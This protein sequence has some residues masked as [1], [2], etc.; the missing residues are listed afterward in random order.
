MKTP[1]PRP[2]DHVRL[3]LSTSSFVS[4]FAGCREEESVR[5]DS[6]FTGSALPIHP[7]CNSERLSPSDQAVG[8]QP[9]TDEHFLPASAEHSPLPGASFQRCGAT[10]VDRRESFAVSHEFSSALTNFEGTQVLHTGIWQFCPEVRCCVC[11]SPLMLPSEELYEHHVSE[12]AM[13]A[14]CAPLSEGLRRSF[15]VDLG[16]LEPVS[17][18]LQCCVCAAPL[19]NGPVHTSEQNQRANEMCAHCISQFPSAS[20][21][22]GRDRSEPPVPSE[23]LF[24][25]GIEVQVSSKNSLLPHCP[26]L[27]C[28]WCHALMSVRVVPSHSALSVLLCPHCTRKRPLRAPL[29]KW[30]LNDPYVYPGLPVARVFSAIGSSLKGGRESTATCK[31]TSMTLLSRG[32]WTGFWSFDSREVSVRCGVLY[33]AGGSSSTGC[34]ASVCGLWFCIHSW[35]QQCCG[36]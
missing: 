7:D 9:Q 3:I 25:L 13:C 18:S 1:E 36:A 34:R 4:S 2:G 29:Q 6:H 8:R 26:F 20:I 32:E 11:L 35:L 19:A 33:K 10:L 21:R 27:H 16:S 31:Q 17:H 12:T 30:L 15:Q 5:L 28:S 23:G 22:S 24:E 14:E